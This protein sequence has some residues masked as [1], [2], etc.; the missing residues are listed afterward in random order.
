MRAS[1]LRFVSLG[2]SSAVSCILLLVSASPAWSGDGRDPVKEALAAM[3]TAESEVEAPAEPTSPDPQEAQYQDRD[4]SNR[5]Q[6]HGHMTQAYAEADFAEG[7]LLTPAIDERIV[8]I[9]EDGTTDYRQL[10]IQF[11]YEI[12]PLDIAVIQFSH[13]RL[14]TSP[15]GRAEDEV[16]VDWAFYERVIGK[17]SYVKIG[18]VPIPRGIFNEIRDVGTILPF[19]RPPLFF[20]REGTFTSETVDGIMFGRNFRADKATTIDA[21]LYYGGWDVFETIDPNAGAIPPGADPDTAVLARA[22]DALGLHVWLNTAVPGLRLG[23]GGSRRNQGGGVLAAPG[24]KITWWDWTSS[25]D[26]VFGKWVYR[27]EFQRRLF[28]TEIA[29]FVPFTVIADTYYGQLGLLPTEKWRF[30]LQFERTDSRLS[31]DFF[32]RS[33][34]FTNLIDAAFA[35]NYAFSPNLVFKAEWHDIER[36]QNVPVT[37]PGVP[38][39]FLVQRARDGRQ[40]IVSISASF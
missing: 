28:R 1:L 9:P 10:A 36:D 15:V 23:A 35:V 21:D 30:Y 32:A 2:P 16:E 39:E 27:S 24:K 6:V 40:L 38:V 37:P 33:V 13:R 3:R 7:G 29:F 25:L 17:S 34:E 26:A 14:G 22:E 19:F 11:R 20:Y 4:R 5:L 31:S 12:S 18:R 8:G